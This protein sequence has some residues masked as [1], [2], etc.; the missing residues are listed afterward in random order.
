MLKG[1]EKVRFRLSR[2]LRIMLFITGEPQRLERQKY[3]SLESSFRKLF[4]NITF[5]HL[6]DLS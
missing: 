1:G 5:R 4:K 2:H 6:R 3:T